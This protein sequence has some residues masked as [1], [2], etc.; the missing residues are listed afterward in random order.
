VI[1][2]RLRSYCATIAQQLCEAIEQ[3]FR[4]DC[5]AIV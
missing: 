4:S 5:A 3:H 1:V 2:Q